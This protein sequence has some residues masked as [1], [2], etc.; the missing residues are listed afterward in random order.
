MRPWRS[1]RLRDGS[2]RGRFDGADVR[3]R[4]IAFTA[5]GTW[6]YVGGTDGRV[7]RLLAAELDA[8]TAA[9][10]VVCDALAGEPITAIGVSP[11]GRW[12]AAGS[13]VSSLAENG[14]QVRSGRLGV[15]ALDRHG[16][17]G[18]RVLDC[19]NLGTRVAD[20]D[21]SGD[22]ALIACGAEQTGYHVWTV[23][24]GQRVA[25]ATE[26]RTTAIRAVHF[27]PKG[28]ELFTSVGRNK[29]DFPGRV[30]LD[31]VA[32][33]PVVALRAPAGATQLVGDASVVSQEEMASTG[34]SEV[35]ELA[36]AE[37]VPWGM[38]ALDV[39]SDGPRR[40]LAYAG[41]EGSIYFY[42]L[43]RRRP[44]PIR[45]FHASSA[46]GRHIDVCFSPDGRQ[47]ASVGPDG[48]RLWDVYPA[49]TYDLGRVGGAHRGTADIAGLGPDGRFVA[50]LPG[51]SAPAG[52]AVEQLVAIDHDGS[53][54]WR[55]PSAPGASLSLSGHRA[56]SPDGKLLAV[57][58]R[59]PTA[60][61][62]R[63]SSLVILDTDSGTER[64][65]YEW[66]SPE[67]SYT[68]WHA[69]QDT[70]LLFSMAERQDT[71]TGD[72]F[73]Y[74]VCAWKVVGPARMASEPEVLQELDDQCTDIC[75][76]TDGDQLAVTTEG[77]LSAG[78]LFVFEHRAGTG[79][80]PLRDRLRAVC[81]RKTYHYCW[82]PAFV[83]GVDGVTLVAV[84]GRSSEVHLYRAADGNELTD[85]LQGH[86]DGV[87][88]C[89][90]YQDRF[91]VTKAKTNGVTL[92]DVAARRAICD[93]PHG[94]GERRIDCVGDLIFIR[95]G[96]IVQVVE[97]DRAYRRLL[98]A[99]QEAHV[100]AYRRP[101]QSAAGA[102]EQ[103]IIAEVSGP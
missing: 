23:R 93:F 35:P 69:R 103:V 90:A 98:G 53:V 72:S 96:D 91:L 85:T 49:E 71:E 37:P 32:E 4:S 63:M 27:G 44:L 59:G 62:P 34:S 92:W 2:L 77:V 24:N 31:V 101:T 17:P 1:T 38:R 51:R 99:L 102:G 5:D 8:A 88:Q 33:S 43:E 28:G 11:D 100:P 21:F 78:R 46:G 75:R 42:D 56:V 3:A 54:L 7:R 61:E 48:L 36:G 83:P 12:L 14:K 67:R 87:Y 9:P 30:R 66:K 89:L 97:P 73:R 81:N 41:G 64:A 25:G 79:S 10:Q 68:C 95:A 18:E 39:A 84:G 76:S 80:G 47:L 19:A 45:G 20:V 22:S 74:R 70:W 6:L 29:L 65:R 13:V 86:R 26:K 58:M 94:E 16:L 57:S 52:P 40:V 50:V 60:A 82:A 15:W 55:Y